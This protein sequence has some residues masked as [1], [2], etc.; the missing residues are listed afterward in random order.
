MRVGLLEIHNSRGKVADGWASF[1]V[2]RAGHASV[3]IANDTGRAY[4]TKATLRFDDATHTI[5]VGCCNRVV[6]KRPGDYAAIK[7]AFT[8]RQ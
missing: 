1:V 4:W 2:R 3:Y 6:F 5:S 8:R 7:S